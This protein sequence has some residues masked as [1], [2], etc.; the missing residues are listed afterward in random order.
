MNNEY[1]YLLIEQKSFNNIIKTN[2]KNLCYIPIIKNESMGLDSFIGTKFIV[3]HKKPTPGFQ[4][5]LKING[6]LTKQD[7]LELYN[8][9]VNEYM[10]AELNELCF[11]K[12]EN[13][14]NF[15][16][17]YTKKIFLKDINLVIGKYEFNEIKFTRSNHNFDISQMFVS[18][19][20]KIIHDIFHE[21]IIEKE[22]K[23][24]NSSISSKSS[25][26]NITKS[27]KITNSDTTETNNLSD[28][29]SDLDSESGSG[30]GSGSGSDTDENSSEYDEEKYFKKEAYKKALGVY[31]FKLDKEDVSKVVI[32]GIPILWV[33]CEKLK[34]NIKNDKIVKNNLHSHYTTCDMCEIV[35][36][37]KN[38]IEL[39]KILFTY[40]TNENEEEMDELIKYYKFA[41][42]YVMTK[43][44]FKNNYDSNKLNL[45]YYKNSDEPIY[46][47]CIFIIKTK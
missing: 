36:N 33:P 20:I 10:L 4:G 28:Q 3:G 1:L 39:D 22:E 32:M 40:K 19:I 31:T 43:K 7:N 6:I 44:E 27:N 12:Y 14:V 25:K 17:I 41:K 16:D 34:S 24:T 47:E 11:L 23:E 46:D 18:K 8:N 30:S 38:E 45:L 9:L 26:S 15:S 21:F 5:Y 13:L 42:N 37:N 29:D 35:N 2:K